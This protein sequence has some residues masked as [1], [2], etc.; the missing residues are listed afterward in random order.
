MKLLKIP[1]TP[2]II[3]FILGGM[4]EENL[5]RALQASEGSISVF[6]TRPISLAFLL[7]GFL[8][9]VYVLRNK[10]RHHGE[11]TLGEKE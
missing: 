4:T 3:G 8:F 6:F 9:V 5:R 2:L 7:A 1:S 10:Y 11:N